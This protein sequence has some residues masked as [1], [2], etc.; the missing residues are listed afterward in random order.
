MKL[1]P[2]MH[3]GMHLVSFRKSGVTSGHKGS[4]RSLT[5]DTLI[6][7][8]CILT[9]IGFLHMN[10]LKSWFGSNGADV[11]ENVAYARAYNTNH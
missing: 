10:F 8:N 9:L 5:S 1:D 6:A 7:F 3:I 4:C 2:G 11:L